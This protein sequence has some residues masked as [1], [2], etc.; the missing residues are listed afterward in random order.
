MPAI[1]PVGHVVDDGAVV[2]RA[3]LGAGLP[4]SVGIVVAY[5][6]DSIDVKARL[7]WSVVVT[8]YARCVREPRELRVYEEMLRPWS[9]GQACEVIR[10]RPRLISGHEL[11]RGTVRQG[12][13]ASSRG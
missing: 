6:V 3:H 7:G 9:D 11:I 2:I 4:G 12:R 5:Q 8:G 13:E 10:I 1:Q